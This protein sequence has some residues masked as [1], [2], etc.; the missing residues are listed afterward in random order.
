MHTLSEPES[1]R[2]TQA[3]AAPRAG[4]PRAPS[5][6]VPS[7]HLSYIDGL[8]GLA[9]SMVLLCHIWSSANSPAAHWWNPLASSYTGVNL[10]LVL[11]GFCLYWPQVK[12]TRP[13]PEPRLAEFAWRR[14]HRILPSYYGALGLFTALAL[15]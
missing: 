1:Q 15:L 9:I 2:E 13:A 8:R 12:P 11:S 7:G 4:P 14:A 10:F 6:A 3:E 5:L